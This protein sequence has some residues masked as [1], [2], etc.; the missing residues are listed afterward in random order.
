MNGRET[1]RLAYGLALL[2][3]PDRLSNALTG[4]RLDGRSRAI[5][6]ILGVRHLNSAIVVSRTDGTRQMGGVVDRMHAASMLCIAVFDY[7]RRRLALIDTAVASLFSL[8][9]TSRPRVEER[10]R[11]AP[12]PLVRA[13]PQD[14][15]A[16]PASANY[17][18]LETGDARRRRRQAALTQ[19]AICEAVDTGKGQ[20]VERVKRKLVR[21]LEA[22]GVSLPPE[23]CLNA[24]AA[25][26][27]WET[28]T[29]STSRP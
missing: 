5:A 17:G 24:V 4:R 2:V 27:T 29:L 15:P 23:A 25:E 26:A 10:V 18:L 3:A 1:T 13:H 21:A 20:P 8:A 7:R 28:S 19:R 11:P 14:P 9:V 6:R 16:A 22:R 12:D